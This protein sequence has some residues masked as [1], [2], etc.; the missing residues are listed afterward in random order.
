MRLQLR[1]ALALAHA[2]ED[3]ERAEADGTGG[4]DG[5]DAALRTRCAS[6]LAAGVESARVFDEQKM[7]WLRRLRLESNGGPAAEEPEFPEEVEGCVE[8]G[9]SGDGEGGADANAAQ[10]VSKAHHVTAEMKKRIDAAIAECE[11]SAALRAEVR[12]CAAHIGSAGSASNEAKAAGVAA[13]A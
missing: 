6:A 8:G 11:K 2:C 4:D 1:L 12:I 9:E 13:E 5:V 10:K 7:E 3:A